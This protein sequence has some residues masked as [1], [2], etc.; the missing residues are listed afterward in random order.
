MKRQLSRFAA[1][2]LAGLCLAGLAAACIE[3]PPPKTAAPLAPKNVKMPDG[4]SLEV[5]CT[6][7]GV[8]MCFDARDNNCNGVLDEGC[9]VHTGILQFTIAWEEPEADVDLNVYDTSGELARVGQVRRRSADLRLRPDLARDNRIVAADRFG[10]LGR[11]RAALRIV[12]GRIRDL[13]VE[14]AR[15][16]DLVGD[17]ERVGEWHPHR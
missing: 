4:Q 3:V 1:A 14:L 13:L 12:F 6:P 2:A 16:I 11:P 5:A 10:A 7:S 15:Q 9:G 17:N 8:E